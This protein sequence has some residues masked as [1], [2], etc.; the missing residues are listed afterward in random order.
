MFAVKFNN[1]IVYSQSTVTAQETVT[2]QFDDT[3]ADHTLEL[4]LFAA[5]DCSIAI[6]NFKLNQYDLLDYEVFYL[7]SDGIFQGILQGTKKVSLTISTP[8]VSWLQRTET[9]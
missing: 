8:I 6:G 5:E 1:Q 9:Y 4:I 2:M 3:P 7:M